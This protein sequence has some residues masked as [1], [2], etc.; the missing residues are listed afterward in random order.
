MVQFSLSIEKSF[1]RDPWIKTGVSWIT[2]ALRTGTAKGLGPDRDEEKWGF[3]PLRMETEKLELLRRRLHQKI[4]AKFQA[5]DCM[6]ARVFNNHL[7]S[8]R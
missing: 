1:S 6:R 7:N 5:R 8:F 3:D 4:D 2:L